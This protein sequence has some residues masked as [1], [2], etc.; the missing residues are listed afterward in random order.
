[1]IEWKVQGFLPI[2]IGLL[3]V[4]GSA[5]F[6]GKASVMSKPH[7]LRAPGTGLYVAQGPPSPI[8]PAPV[9]GTA[10]LSDGSAAPTKRQPTADNSS[11]PRFRSIREF[12]D[13]L[14][15]VDSSRE[16]RSGSRHGGSPTAR[17]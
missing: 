3:T 16:Y 10:G 1:M 15:V 7:E 9:T 5:L 14:P 13:D 2:L 4:N 8:K 11:R 6:G 12:Q 17:N